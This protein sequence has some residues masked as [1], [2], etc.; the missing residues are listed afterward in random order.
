MSDIQLD[1]EWTERAAKKAERLVPKDTP[2]GLPPLE[3]LPQEGD[4]MFLGKGDKKQP[5]VV[6]ERQYHHEGE[7]AWTIIL[8]LDLPE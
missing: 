5:F 7:D 8:I 3:C 6:V 4:V 1:I 2:L